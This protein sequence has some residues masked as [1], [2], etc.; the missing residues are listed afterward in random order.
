MDFFE[1]PRSHV[2]LSLHYFSIKAV[3]GNMAEGPIA[4]YFIGNFQET[5]PS[6]V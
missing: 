6:R 4:I 2:F 3:V 5:E 1:Q